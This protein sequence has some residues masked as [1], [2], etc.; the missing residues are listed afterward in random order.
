MFVV[1]WEFQVKPGCQNEFEKVYGPGGD[2]DSLFRSDANHAGT[3][4]FRDTVRPCVYL[5]TDYWHSRK[6][7]EEFLQA[8]R[9][10]YHTL[11]AAS[12]KLTFAERH[13]GSFETGAT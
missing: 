1:L 7:Y 13:I 4:L 2:W 10:D 9:N 5:T 11:D 12:E 3:Y 8:R 6:S